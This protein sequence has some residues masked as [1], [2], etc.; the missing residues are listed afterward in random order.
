MPAVSN[1]NVPKRGAFARAFGAG[2]EAA[3]LPA[4]ATERLAR[5]MVAVARSRVR[6]GGSSL[7]DG[8][9]WQ[10]Y[11]TPP[12]PINLRRLRDR[13]GHAVRPPPPF[14]GHPPA[15]DEDRDQPADHRADH[16]DD[17]QAD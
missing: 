12:T 6:I 10:R 8:G 17:E 2:A 4:T 5:E 7:T 1:P 14:A 3:W 13:R 9:V 16:G 15:P 11:S